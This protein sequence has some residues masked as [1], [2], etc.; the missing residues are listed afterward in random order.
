[1]KRFL[2][3]LT[4][5]LVTAFA[6]LF[7]GCASDQIF[8][9][10][11]GE[12]FYVSAKN[13]NDLFRMLLAA[14]RGGKWYQSCLV[15]GSEGTIAF[16]D[17]SKITFKAKDLTLV[18]GEPRLSLE[19]GYWRLDGKKL[20]IP[21]SDQSVIDNCRIVCASRGGGQMTLYLNNGKKLHFVSRGADLL[22]NV[23][24][25]KALNP[26]IQ[27]PPLKSRKPAPQR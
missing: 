2:E 5:L 10:D 27:A 23:R 26:S 19:D 13:E 20:S 9:V 3:I 8:T 4:A 11:S 6:G 16:N 12:P 22:N 25:E 18:T 7:G 21:A 24:L 14:L 1:M 15:N 17:G